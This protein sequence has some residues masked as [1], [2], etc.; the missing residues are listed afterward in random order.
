M[1][2]MPRAANKMNYIDIANR[3]ACFV[4]V[5]MTGYCE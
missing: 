3:F 1:C 4:F 2:A 5:S